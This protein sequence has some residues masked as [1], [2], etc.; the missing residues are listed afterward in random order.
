VM[1]MVMMRVVVAVLADKPLKEP[2]RPFFS[3]AV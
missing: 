3:A 1:V 2:Y